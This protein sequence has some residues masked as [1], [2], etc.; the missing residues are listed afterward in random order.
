MAG[1]HALLY[2]LLGAVA[3]AF[4]TQI[5]VCLVVLGLLILA[6]FFRGW[7]RVFAVICIFGIVFDLLYLEL[8]SPLVF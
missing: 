6:V 8:S 3:K 7:Y 5:A 2:I 4:E 1:H